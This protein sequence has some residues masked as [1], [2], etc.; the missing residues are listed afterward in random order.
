[1]EYIHLLNKYIDRKVDEY[2]KELVMEIQKDL[3]KHFEIMGVA[4]SN[5]NVSKLDSFHL[6]NFS[7][8]GASV[9]ISQQNVKPLVYD[10]FKNMETH[11]DN[12]TIFKILKERGYIEDRKEKNYRNKWVNAI[13]LSLGNL[14][15]YNKIEAI[16]KKGK[17]KIYRLKDEK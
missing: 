17:I 14:C 7:I 12:P 13:S 15:R 8:N 5:S 1:M 9:G 16:D 3:K 11:L 10:L 4:Q 2:R 6:L